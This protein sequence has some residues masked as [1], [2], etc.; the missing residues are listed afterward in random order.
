[1]RPDYIGDF[2]IEY[3]EPRHVIPR[4][5]LLLTSLEA[6]LY[7]KEQVNRSDYHWSHELRTEHAH[8]RT[9]TPPNA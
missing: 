4:H 2:K 6:I 3:T 1:M 7:V 9:R 5:R 8:G